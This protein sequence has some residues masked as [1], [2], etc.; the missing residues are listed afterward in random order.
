M[1]PGGSSRRRRRAECDRARRTAAIQGPR[2][3]YNGGEVRGIYYGG[4]VIYYGG[5]VRGVS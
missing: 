1:L 5:E 3:T 4:G 2:G